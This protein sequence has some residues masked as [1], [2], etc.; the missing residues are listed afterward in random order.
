MS[1]RRPSYRGGRI[2]ADADRLA[3]MK[4]NA[5]LFSVGGKLQS[6]YEPMVEDAA[7]SQGYRDVAI[8]KPLVIRYL[9]FF[10]Q[11]GNAQE[12]AE[13]LMVS[14][15]V[16]TVEAKKPAAESVNYYN[17]E[18]RFQNGRGRI[19]AL[20]G[21]TYG[22]ELIYYAKSYTGEPVKMTTKIMELDNPESVTKQLVS[23]LQTI[24]S[25]PAFLEF[26]PYF[27][28]AQTSAGFLGKILRLLDRD[29]P[30]V[31]GFNVD[32][33]FEKPHM[34]LLRSGRVVCVEAGNEGMLINDYELDGTNRLVRKDN[35]NEFTDS[36]YFVIQVNSESIQAYEEFEYFQNAAELLALTNRSHPQQN[37]RDFVETAVDG[38]RT[39]ADLE[40][41][42]ELKELADEL[43]DEESLAR[44]K[45]L[46]K[47]LSREVKDLYRAQYEGALEGVE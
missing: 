21:Q 45:A 36:S 19:A 34:P 39:F 22:H 26:L 15:F 18:F 32:L 47:G 28:I 7:R 14:S 30:I 42:A 3:L 44:F 41:I 23:G 9:H 13:E 31:P 29:D 4:E 5:C 16:K 35:G 43:D 12:S 38:F 11:F 37:L 24:G 33:H 10:L 17:P 27:A 46:F 8:G 1:S 6:L 40:T 2:E 20:G 25:M